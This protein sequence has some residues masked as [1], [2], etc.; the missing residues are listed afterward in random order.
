MSV[1]NAQTIRARA[2]LD[3]LL[4]AKGQ[5]DYMYSNPNTGYFVNAGLGLN[6]QRSPEFNLE[7]GKNF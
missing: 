5:L 6:S 4:N 1:G 2:I 7:F 3:N